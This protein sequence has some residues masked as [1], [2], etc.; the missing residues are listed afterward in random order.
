MSPFPWRFILHLAPVGLLVDRSRGEV[1]RAR[2][3][4]PR[5]AATMLTGLSPN[6]GTMAASRIV[7]GM[8]EPTVWPASARVIHEWFPASERGFANAA[9]RGGMALNNRGEPI[10]DASDTFASFVAM[11]AESFRGAARQI[12]SSTET[13]PWRTTP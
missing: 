12:R 3:N 4:G 8:G 5:S 2:G 10:H 11:S 1:V 6:L 7:M 13:S 9:S